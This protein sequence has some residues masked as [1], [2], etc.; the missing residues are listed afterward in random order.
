MIKK[1]DR[2]ERKTD[3]ERANIE[4]KKESSDIGKHKKGKLKGH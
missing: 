3:E 4:E 2:R 1:K